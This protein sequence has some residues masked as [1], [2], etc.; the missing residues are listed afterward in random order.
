MMHIRRSRDRGKGDYDWLKTRYSFSFA[1][2]YDPEFMG[3]R[4]LR[5]INED[6]IAPKGGFPTHAHRDMEILTYVLKGALQHSDSMGNGSIIRPGEVQRMS[7]GTGVTHSEFNA[8]NDEA[9][10]LL[11]IW[12]QPAARGLQPSYEQRDFSEARRGN[13]CLV[14]SKD[15]RDGSVRL[16]Q[17]ASVYA[18]VLPPGQE[19]VHSIGRD[20]HVWVQVI[21]GTLSINDAKL[22]AG[23]GVAISDEE[24]IAISAHTRAHALLFD[25]C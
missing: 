10:H 19:V 15:G 8:S 18:T 16:H 4:D 23:D 11:Q 13:L 25:L 12:I 7:A 22:E 1:N 20:R 5:V 21:D 17:D 2:Y 3:F 6:V 9:L 14:A 24:Q